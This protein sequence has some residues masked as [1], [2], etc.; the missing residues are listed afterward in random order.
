MKYCLG[1]FFF[2]LGRISIFPTQLLLTD[3]LHSMSGLKVRVIAGTDCSHGCWLMKRHTH[4]FLHWERGR[5]VNLKDFAKQ[6]QQ[7]QAKASHL[8]ASVGLC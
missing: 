4:V 1:F 2:F 3:L 5:W 6:Q 8:I 7:Q